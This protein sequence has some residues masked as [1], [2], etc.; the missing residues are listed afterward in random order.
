[1]GTVRTDEFRKDAVR[2]ALSSKDQD[3]I[4]GIKFPEDGLSPKQ[5]ADDL[6]VG[7][8]TLNKWITA[9]RKQ[10][11]DDACMTAMT[12]ELAETG[13][14][15]HGFPVKVQE[16]HIRSGQKSLT[17]RSEPEKVRPES[18]W[19]RDRDSNPGSACTDNGFRDRRIRPLCHLSMT[20]AL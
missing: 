9:H 15:T 2:I 20:P 11:Q 6:G 14:R 8:S 17:A 5:I 18:R 7:M 1:M 19:R 12:D 10:A 16:T 4:R 13:E 3:L